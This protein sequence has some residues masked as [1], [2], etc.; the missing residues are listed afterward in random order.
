MQKKILRAPEAG[1]LVNPSSSIA[2]ATA[3]G[4]R[5]STDVGEIR[6]RVTALLAATMWLD[7]LHGATSL[8]STRAAWLLAL[9]GLGAQLAFT[10]LEALVAAAAWQLMGKTARWSVLAPRLLIA[11]SFETLAVSVAGGRAHV[12]LAWA[13]V[14]AGPRAAHGAAAAHGLAEAFAA[15]GLLALGRVLF[16]AWLQSRAA[17]AGFATALALV[18]AMWLVSRLAAWWTFDLLQGRSFQR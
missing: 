15:V 12:P 2:P 7:V 4:A 3:S 9:A 11:S 16:S 13:V 10:G 5:A 14:L 17:R 1:E 8:V 6:V 18:V